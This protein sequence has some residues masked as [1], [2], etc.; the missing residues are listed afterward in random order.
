MKLNIIDETRNHLIGFLKKVLEGNYTQ[1]ELESF[2]ISGYQNEVF[3]RIRTTV[4]QI[5]TG[6]SQGSDSNTRTL[7]TDDRAAIEEIIFELERQ[8]N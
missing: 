1:N 2:I 3:E 8:S 6:K 7:S 4:V 5:I